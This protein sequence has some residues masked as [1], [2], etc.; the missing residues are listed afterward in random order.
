MD[1]WKGVIK[2]REEKRE[3]DIEEKRGDSFLPDLPLVVGQLRCA[4]QID[5]KLSKI[6][7]LTA[8]RIMPLSCNSAGGLVSSI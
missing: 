8:S 3:T 7:L 4:C 5:F 2:L 6:L 1:Y